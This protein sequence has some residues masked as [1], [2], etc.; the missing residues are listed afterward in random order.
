MSTKLLQKTKVTNR[1]VSL[2]P[3]FTYGMI[4]EDPVSGHRVG[5]LD[6]IKSEDVQKLMQGSRAVLAI[7]DPPY[8]VDINIEFGALPLDRY[9]NWSNQWVDNAIKALADDT[10][11]YIWLGADI[12]NAL[13]PLPDFMLLMREKP[14]K[15]RNYIT[16]RNQR[17][18]GTQKNWMAIR[19]ELL[20][21]IKGQPIFN[22]TAEYTD[23]QKKTKGYYKQVGGKRTENFERSKSTTIRAGNVWHDIQQVFYLMHEN[24]EGCFAQ[25]PLKSA[26]RIMNASSNTGDLVIDFFGH[27]GSTLLQG[28]LSKRLVYTMDIDPE[29]CKVMVARL[30]HYRRTGETGWGRTRVLVDG[31]VI[32]NE[33]DLLG[34]QGLLDLSQ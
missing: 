7:Q 10:S 6:A 8:N 18:Y 30:L 19:Q 3:D 5:C 20:Y 28:E 33:Q 9:I 34:P 27:S 32:L 25:K 24:I 11:L 13:Q 15:I 14:L 16:M 4:W 2:I 1:A 26:Q 17:G 21:Y 29:Y 12:K 31:K 23:I 22:V